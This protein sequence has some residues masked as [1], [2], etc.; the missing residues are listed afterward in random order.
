MASPKVSL[1]PVRRDGPSDCWDPYARDVVQYTYDLEA[2][3]AEA[4]DSW[5]PWALGWC[6]YE[7]DIKTSLA[8]MWLLNCYSLL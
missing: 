3:V 1:I 7:Y 6:A 5:L 2:C 8:F 4:R